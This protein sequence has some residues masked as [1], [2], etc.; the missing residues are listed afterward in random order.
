M[1]RVAF[2]RMATWVTAAG[3]L[4]GTFRTEANNLAI[5]NT[6]IIP[7]GGASGVVQFDITWE[8]SWRHSDGTDSAFFHD[9]AW[10]FFKV[11]PE[12]A[13]EWKHVKLTGTGT[14]PAGY[15][16]GSAGS[17]IEL[18]VPPDRMGVFVRRSASNQGA[19]PA[20]S[21]GVQ[22]RWTLADSGVLSSDR[23]RIR[24][25][26][27]EMV[28]V[29]EGT[30]TA[31][32]GTSVNAFFPTLINTGISTQAP[33]N[34]SGEIQGGYPFAGTAPA[35][36]NYP[37]GYKAF[38]MMKY[39]VSEGLYADMLNLLTLDQATNRR[40]SV[41]AR[42][43]GSHP[44]YAPVHRDKAL[45][46]RWEDGVAFSD[47]SGLRPFTELEYEKACRGPLPPVPSEFAWGTYNHV[48]RT[49]ISGTVG[50]GTETALPAAANVDNLNQGSPVRVGLLAEPGATREDGGAS[51]WGIMD[52]SGNAY[53]RT[54]RQDRTTFTDLHGDGV[55]TVSGDADVATW[56]IGTGDNSPAGSGY[57]G[58]PYSTGALR[59]YVSDRNY[60]QSSYSLTTL[61]P[62]WRSARSVQ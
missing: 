4:L 62:G 32:E 1:K 26:G 2:G 20:T 34:V 28:S 52:L 51:Y 45:V 24:A 27:V 33:V 54:V 14:N 48:L 31:G 42:I 50:S 41:T 56:P 30:F 44:T 61:Y 47:W 35:S 40:A 16:R 49:S 25:L 12:G 55:L 60:A 36:T 8:N 3:L 21:T 53:E 7:A 11:L 6:R 13:P 37:N 39:M 22:V 46:M 59:M 5:T 29:A 38:Y 9:A 58:G 17:S 18:V 43:T 23:V 15:S 10:V 57:R 19:G